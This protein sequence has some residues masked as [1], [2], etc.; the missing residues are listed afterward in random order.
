MR[1]GDCGKHLL[2]SF[3]P[4]GLDL[5]AEMT[6]LERTLAVLNH[7]IPDRVPVAL[8]NFLMACRMA[9]GDFSAT[10][11]SGE[12]LAEA[13][14]A[15][16]REF[17]HNVIMHENGVCAEAEAMGCGIH[18]PADGPALTASNLTRPPIRRLARKR[19]GGEPACWACSILTECCPAEV[20]RK[21]A[22]TRSKS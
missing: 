17:G 16:W 10:L 11:R 21:F 18:Y 4:K 5:M 20:S 12:I 7:K 13:E 3:R 22:G 2:N 8:H 9:G 6:S 1:A 15:A 19:P 14:L